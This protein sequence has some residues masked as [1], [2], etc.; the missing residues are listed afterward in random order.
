[1]LHL[2]VETEEKK[3]LEKQKQMFSF[4]DCFNKEWLS[5]TN[6][7]QKLNTLIC[8]ICKQIV[9]HAME[10]HCDK[11]ENVDQV[12]LVGE[13][14]LQKYLKQN[15]GKCP[16]QQHDYCK[17]SQSRSMAKVVSELSVICPQQFELKKNESN[18][19]IKS[20]EHW[21]ESNLNS[22]TGCNYEGKIK[23]LKDH[24]DK[25]CNLISNKQNISSEIMNRLKEL[26]NMI[27]N[28]QSQ[29]K[30]MKDNEKN[31]QNEQL[32]IKLEEQINN[33][34]YELQEKNQTITVLTNNIQQLKIDINQYNIEF[35]KQLEQFQIKFDDLKQY[36]QNIETNLKSQNMQIE[37]K[38]K[39]QDVNTFKYNKNCQY[40]VSLL[41]SLKNG[42]NFLLV[43][44]NNKQ[45][46]IRNS[47]WNDYSFGIFLLGKNIVLTVVCEKF[48][49]IKIK[50]SHLWIKH[51]SSKI[52]CSQLGYPK[53]EGPG[54]GQPGWW[55]YRK[56]ND[57]NNGKIYGEET[58]LKEIH[59]GSG[60]GKGED[61]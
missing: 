58:L 16:I 25:S 38:E 22:K 57:E 40:M 20:E 1:M 55:D 2:N 51:P 23:D 17:F 29:I 14:C 30:K 15:N 46:E 53:D 61:N 4:S 52:D 7:P 35:K 50:T 59:Y 28:L 8:C 54:K 26:P 37:E 45:I 42:V 36:K 48:G 5:L 24:L 19:E 6:K 44:E 11:H 3:N 31:K 43:T 27:K 49:H 13:E 39:E 60:C 41:L 21:N 10:L 33:L 9:N 18:E 47:E 32:K 34:K 12:Y 56:G